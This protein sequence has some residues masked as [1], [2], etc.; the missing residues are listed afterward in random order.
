VVGFWGECEFFLEFLRVWG[1]ILNFIY[2]QGDL[3]MLVGLSPHE[4]K[5]ITTSID[6][7]WVWR[8]GVLLAAVVSFHNGSD[9]FRSIADQVIR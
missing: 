7:A 1:V 9:V 6:G 3:F 4:N 2:N 5:T 8:F